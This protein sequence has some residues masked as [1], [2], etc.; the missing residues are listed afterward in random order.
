MSMQRSVRL[1]DAILNLR[2]TIILILRHLSRRPGFLGT[3]VTSCGSRVFD[4]LFFAF[5][6][7][8]PEIEKGR[9][10]PRALQS[11]YFFLDS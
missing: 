6:I 7:Y 3:A 9:D 5:A 8:P 2:F 1:P 4:L 10:L 11:F